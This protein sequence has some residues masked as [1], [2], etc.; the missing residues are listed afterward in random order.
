MAKSLLQEEVDENIKARNK[1]LNMLTYMRPE[2]SKTQGS[3]CRHYLGDL[4]SR[5]RHGNYIKI[6]LD[7][8][9]HL[10]SI[11]FCAHHDTVHRQG[12]IQKV[13]VDMT[14]GH[15]F[16][17]GSDCL[18]ADC[19][20]GVWLVLEL[21]KNKTPGVYVV[22]AAEEIGCKGSE[23]LVKDDPDWLQHID[24]CISFD[25]Y[26]TNSIITHQMG[27][28]TASQRFA[29]SLAGALDMDL[30]PDSGGSYTDSNEFA[31][32]VPECTNLSVGYYNQHTNKEY[33]DIYFAMYLRKKLL[34]ADWS[35]LVVDRDP[36]E[37]D[38]DWGWYSEQSV[39]SSRGGAYPSGF[40]GDDDIAE[41]FEV[42]I[43]HPEEI[44]E[45]LKGWGYTREGLLEDLG[46]LNARKTGGR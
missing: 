30:E 23:A 33:Q 4:M 43:D 38:Y 41:I 46:L 1:L 5:D 42:V 39:T 3:F 7:D 14:V 2:G 11:M 10:P 6:I 36:T 13:S 16:A 19:T 40:M 24:Y 12:G 20:T 26:G 25:R 44:A 9:G 21:I 17:E 45:L 18:G 35:M 15:A 32:I 8:E 22:F 37:V 34:A 31:G 29:Y 27:E 28:R